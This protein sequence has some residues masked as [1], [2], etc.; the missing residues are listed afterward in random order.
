MYFIDYDGITILNAVYKGRGLNR[1]SIM[2]SDGREIEE[3][4]N[5]LFAMHPNDNPR[6]KI[7]DGVW[8]YTGTDNQPISMASK[9]TYLKNNHDILGLIAFLGLFLWCSSIVVF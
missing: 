7:I 5:R 4:G 8:H 9:K 6:C 3:A 2:L 1:D